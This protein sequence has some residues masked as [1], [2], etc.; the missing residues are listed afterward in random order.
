MAATIDRVNNAENESIALLN[1]ARDAYF[2]NAPLSE[3][4]QHEQTMQRIRSM[5]N[6]DIVAYCIERKAEYLLNG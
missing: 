1:Q 5:S 4:D 3:R 6:A 2:R